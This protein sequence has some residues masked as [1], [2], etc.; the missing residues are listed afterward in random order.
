MRISELSE[1]T[2]VSVATIKWYVREGLL[3]PGHRRSATQAEYDD[4][5]VARLRLI[6]AL[7]EVPGLPVQRIKAIVDLLD[8]PHADLVAS[9]ADALAQLPP[10]P[11]GPVAGPA[12]GRPSAAEALD[13]IG[14]AYDPQFPAVAQLDAALGAATAVIPFDED[15]FAEY[16]KHL[17]AIAESEIGK[18]PDDPAA[19][20]PYG[21]LGTALYE[22]VLL[23]L[24]RLALYDA[25]S[26]LLPADR[27][28]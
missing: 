27:P 20:V 9:L 5:H 6:K 15:T 21:V 7:G 24:R 14:Y 17:R 16:G 18:I 3:A 25:A 11:A 23:A 10:Y 28:E 2:G 8:H 4:D 13:L 1:R 19:A 26:R 12:P 22:P